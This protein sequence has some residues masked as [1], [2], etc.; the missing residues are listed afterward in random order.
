MEWHGFAWKH[1]RSTHPCD[2]STCKTAL[3]SVREKSSQL[4][5]M[6]EI[7]ANTQKVLSNRCSSCQS[8]QKAGNLE[9]GYWKFGMVTC[10]NDQANRRE[11]L[12]NNALYNSEAKRA[13]CLFECPWTPEI[14]RSWIFWNMSSRFIGPLTCQNSEMCKIISERSTGNC[15]EIAGYWCK[16]LRFQAKASKQQR[17][18]HFRWL[19]IFEANTVDGSFLNWMCSRTMQRRELKPLEVKTESCFL[20]LCP[21]PR[22]LQLPIRYRGLTALAAWRLVP[23]NMNGFTIDADRRVPSLQSR[24]DLTVQQTNANDSFD[25]CVLKQTP[26][27]QDS[28]LHFHL[29][30]VL[31]FELLVDNG[32]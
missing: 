10:R 20:M 14:Q 17:V 13:K 15:R 25:S 32:W 1:I 27:V 28:F 9:Q 29:F 7:F 24:K 18:P 8:I 23:G 22:L 21:V 4:Y 5:D 19:L 31:H 16:C 30:P 26:A 2:W 6:H 3:S 12:K 11:W